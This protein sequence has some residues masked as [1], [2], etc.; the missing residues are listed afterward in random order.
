MSQYILTNQEAIQFY[1]KHPHIDFNVI[2]NI[3]TNILQELMRNISNNLDS[4]HHNLLLKELSSRLTALENSQKSYSESISSI[5]NK[6]LESLIQTM[7]ETIKSNNVDSEKTIIQSISEKNELFL[8]KIDSISQNK[9]L[10]NLFTNEIAILNQ[11]LL[12]DSS[13]NEKIIQTIH[14]TLNDSFKTR[15]DSF[16][17]S[18][19]S[20]NNAVYSEILQKLNKNNDAVSLVENYFQKQTG[21]NSKGK[22]GE[23]KLE[24]ILSEV[25]P[26]ASIKNTSGMTACGD[27]LI[28]R[29]DKNKLLIDTKDYDTVIPIKEVEKI[30]RDVEK[31]ACN[32]IL[33]SQNSGIA[34]KNDFEINIHNNNIIIFIHYANYDPQKILLAVNIIDHLEPIIINKSN[35]NEELIS[36]ETVLA[37]NKEYQELASQ[38]L[39]LIQSIKK[40]QQELIHQIQKINMPSLTKYLEKK[41]ANTGKMGFN[42]EICNN[43]IGKNAKAL[44]AH[45][46]R[47]QQKNAQI[48]TEIIQTETITNYFESK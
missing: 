19:S 39:N 17:A 25:F 20:S 48:N 15:V 13:S 40:N 45:K 16:F 42:C 12:K 35:N 2:N 44:A 38:K 6:H 30:I 11:S 9:E 27:F 3:F 23:A 34:Q 1:D 10:K 43:F 41:F 21:S 5:L 8:S 22:Q 31:N 26:S 28:E 7:R 46:R 4:N 14:N 36:S 33:L 47:C 37:I 29:K 18:Q 32:G 24:L